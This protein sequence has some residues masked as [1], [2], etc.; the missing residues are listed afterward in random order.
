M[1]KRWAGE[2]SPYG[3]VSAASP[4]GGRGRRRRA[5]ALEL[6]LR[7]RAEHH[8]AVG[9]AGGDRRRRVADRCGAATTAAAPLHVRE[10][11]L[12][13]AQRRGQPGGIVAVVAV[14]GKA[15]DLARIET[16]V[17]AGGE[18]RPQR[19]LHLGLRRLAV[20][21]VGGLADAGDG[22]VTS[23]RSHA[24]TP[25]RIRYGRTIVQARAEV[26]RASSAR[27]A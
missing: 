17:L 10:A 1:A 6:P 4:A 15:V 14:R 27:Y 21:V 26:T 20:L 16:G 9:V 22:H 11:Q 7:E 23:D 12:G 19:Q 8:H 24:G 25:F 18:D 3:K 5:E 2:I 13:Q